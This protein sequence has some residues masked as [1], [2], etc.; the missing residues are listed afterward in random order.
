MA[1][2]AIWRVVSEIPVLKTNAGPDRELWVQRFK[3]E[4]QCLIQYVENK[5][6]DKGWF[7]LESKKEG[8]RKFGNC[9]YIHDLFKYEFDIPITYPTT[10][11]EVAVSKLDGKTAK[12]YRGGK[13]CPTDH[14]KPLWARNV[15]NFGLAHLMALVLGPWLAVEIP[16][17]IQKGVIQPK[18]KCS[19]CRSKS[20]RK[21]RGTCDRLGFCFPRPTCV[22]RNLSIPTYGLRKSI[23]LNTRLQDCYVEASA[24]IKVWTARKSST[25]SISAAMAHS[26]SPWEVV[27]NPL[28]ANSSLLLK[29]VLRQQLQDKCH[30]MPHKH[31]DTKHSRRLKVKGSPM[32]EGAQQRKVRTTMD[33]QSKP[34][35]GQLSDALRCKWPGKESSKEKKASLRQD[36]E[37]RYAE[38]VATT[39]VLPWDCGTAAW[40]AQA[41]LPEA[42]KRGHLSE[43]TLTIHGLPTEGYQ[44]LY[45]AVVEP[46]LWNPS[47]TPKRYSLELGKAIKQRLWEALCHQDTIPEG[48]QDP[49]L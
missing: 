6:A 27:K 40:E 17:L 36:L 26:Y 33:S 15:P 21:N 25:Q 1:D 32:V 28:I 20:L 45:H 8:T 42:R 44:A 22:R 41:L 49:L 35:A 23:L 47:G 38:H 46:M 34:P 48:A 31:G 10:A 5:S 43:D 19:Q 14:F 9:W 29:L 12:M 18:E 2:E 3:E 11:P 16:D 4:Y 37:D 30:P 39:Q 7:R 24:L 13:I